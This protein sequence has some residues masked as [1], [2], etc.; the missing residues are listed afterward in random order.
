MKIF[1]LNDDKHWQSQ[2]P[3]SKVIDRSSMSIM[4]KEQLLQ[5]FIREENITVAERDTALFQLFGPGIKI[6]DIKDW[7]DLDEIDNVVMDNR[8][9]AKGETAI[10]SRKYRYVESG[11]SCGTGTSSPL[12][13]SINKSLNKSAGTTPKE[14]LEEILDDLDKN[15][16]AVTNLP[17]DR[18]ENL[19]LPIPI[20]FIMEWKSDGLWKKEVIFVIKTVADY[21]SIINYISKLGVFRG[22][23]SNK[24]IDADTIFKEIASFPSGKMPEETKASLN[25]LIE[26]YNALHSI[27]SFVKVDPA[28]KKEDKIHI[29]LIYND[30]ERSI[31]DININMRD[32][33]CY[34]DVRSCPVDEQFKDGYIPLLLLEFIGNPIGGL[35][36]VQAII[37][38]KCAVRDGCQYHQGYRTRVVVKPLNLP[39]VPSLPAE[40]TIQPFLKECFDFIKNT[41]VNEIITFGDNIDY[42][43]CIINIVCQGDTHKYNVP[44]RQKPDLGGSRSN[45][46][47]P[48]RFKSNGLNGSNDRLPR[49]NS[50]TIVVRGR[51]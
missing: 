27:W 17:I 50:R 30:K 41:F 4:E 44:R 23:H 21:W 20:A 51:G 29:P 24:D 5:Q 19:F 12:T 40:K 25:K 3:M 48:N 36:N 39:L 34:D 2:K 10:F 14:S 9:I 47:S 35:A 31:N 42:T 26:Q 1:S 11:E 46:R 22:Q 32:P 13:G 7:A 38:N 16:N 37:F 43:K 49:Q 8:L 6:S 33:D 15:D 45:S 28:T 18:G